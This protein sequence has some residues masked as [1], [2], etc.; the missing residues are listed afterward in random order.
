[1]GSL[2]LETTTLP[3][4]GPLEKSLNTDVL[5]VGG[6]LAGVLCAH[7][8]TELGVDCVLVEA[9]NICGGVTAHTTAKLTAQHGFLYRTLLDHFGRSGAAAYLEANL[10]ALERYRTLCQRIDCDFEERDSYVYTLDDPKAAQEEFSALQELG[11]PAT[12]ERQLPLPFPVA[13]AVRFP[14]QGQFH[15]LKFVRG[16]LPGLTVYA[17]SPIR[18]IRPGYAITDQGHVVT[19]KHILICTHFPMLNRWGSYFI[20]LYQHRSYLLALEGAPALPGMYVDNAQGGLTFRPCGPYLLFGGGDHRTGK[21]GGG[22]SELETLAQRYWPKAQ[23]KY[24]WATQDCMSLDGVPYIG[25]YSPSTPGLYVA[26]GFNKWG[27]TNSMVAALLLGDLV[28]GRDTPWA[29]LF[30]PNRSM[31]CPQLFSN[32]ISS[33]ADLLTPT[34]PR[35]PHMGCALKWNSQEHSWDCPCHGSR[36]RED[37]QLINGP[38]QEGLSPK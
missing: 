32:L 26:T 10:T 3:D 13:G 29:K 12:L 38:A 2:W 27:M 30:A 21:A 25:P 7:R 18:K 22:W 23:V 33:A 17:H 19:A 20:K 24:R 14:D 37:G 5:I 36:F 4:Y 11:Y 8:L 1:M 31:L 34:R 15:P 6:G 9:E 35:C 16:L 28:T